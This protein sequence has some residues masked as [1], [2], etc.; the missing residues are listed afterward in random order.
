M[1]DGRFRAI[2]SW[3][4]TLGRPNPMVLGNGT[5]ARPGSYYFLGRRKHNSQ[6]LAAGNIFSNPWLGQNVFRLNLSFYF[7]D[8]YRKNFGLTANFLRASRLDDFKRSYSFRL[9]Y[10]LVLGP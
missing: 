6:T 10:Q 2:F 1:A 5:M 8:A 3:H 9:C 7:F 4:N